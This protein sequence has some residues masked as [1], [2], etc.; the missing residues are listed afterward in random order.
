MQIWGDLNTFGWESDDDM[1]AMHML[2][3]V[4]AHNTSTAKED[5]NTLEV[6]TEDN[7]KHKTQE[8]SCKP[9]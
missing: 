3:V 1:N 7:L 6:R 8:I 9:C 4:C 5:T 2:S